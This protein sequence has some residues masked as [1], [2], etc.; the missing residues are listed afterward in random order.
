MNLL[1]LCDPEAAA[2][3]V[4]SNVADAIRMML[5]RHVGAV[6]VGFSFAAI[7]PTT[8]AI[9]ADRYQRLAGTIFGFLFAVGLI[10]GMAFPWS[11][12][13]ISQ[14]YGVRSGMVLPLIGGIAIAVIV[15]IIAAREKSAVPVTSREP[16]KRARAT[17]RASKR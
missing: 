6:I 15:T 3:H 8:L 16:A 4:Q 17:S 11:I 7:Y 10:G 2:V 5:N 12:G 13:H 14:V 1:E 9:A